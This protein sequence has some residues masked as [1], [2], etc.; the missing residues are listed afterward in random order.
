MKTNIKFFTHDTQAHRNYKLRALR[1]MY[2]FEGYGR[3]WALNEMIGEAEAC[4]LDLSTPLKKGAVASDLGMNIPEFDKFISFMSDPE[5]CGLISILDDGRVT[6]ERVKEDLDRVM[7]NRI[8]KRGDAKEEKT[9]RTFDETACQNKES[10]CT[11]SEV[12]KNSE[13]SLPPL[14]NSNNSNK[15]TSTRQKGKTARRF[16]ETARTFYTDKTRQDKTRLDKNSAA[17]SINLSQKGKSRASPDSAAADFLISEVLKIRCKDSTG[18]ILKQPEVSAILDKLKA[19]NLGEAF[20]EF[21]IARILKN[22]D[23]KKPAGFLKHTLLNLSDYADYVDDFRTNRALPTK[24]ARPKLPDCFCAGDLRISDDIAQCTNCGAMWELIDNSWKSI[25]RDEA[26][27][28][29]G[30]F[31]KKSVF[32]AGLQAK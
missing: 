30:I 12:D 6:T 2:G 4:I 23:V 5:T 24:P 16:N 13:D 1:A 17:D 20:L 26:V 15:N 7:K 19:Q 8:R 21:L 27:D 3:F 11:K 31:K 10:T 25:A 28:I 32:Q 9:A 22:P 18:L 29:S 14:E